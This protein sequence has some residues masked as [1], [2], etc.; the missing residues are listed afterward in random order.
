[1]TGR[2]PARLVGT[3]DVDPDMKIDRLGSVILEFGGDAFPVQATFT[4]STQLVSYQRMHFFGT[5]DGSKSWIPFNA[6]PT[7]R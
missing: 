4:F 7:V 6:R 5:R 3:L 1:M 2:E